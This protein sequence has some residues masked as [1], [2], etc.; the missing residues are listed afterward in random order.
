MT[1]LVV[2]DEYLIADDVM[3][4]LLDQ[5]A[6]VVGPIATLEAAMAAVAG[7]RPDLAVLDINLRGEPVFPLADL[8]AAQHVPFVFTTGYDSGS[9]PERFA[10]VPRLEKPI[11]TADLLATLDRLGD[12]Q[13]Q[14]AMPPAPTTA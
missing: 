3:Q 13:A 5:G 4:V 2:E 11:R 7:Q 9:M 10:A 6:K 12:P 14:A 1:I 8:L